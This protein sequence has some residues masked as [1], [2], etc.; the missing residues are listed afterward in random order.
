MRFFQQSQCFFL[1]TYLDYSFPIFDWLCLNTTN[2]PKKLFV[3]NDIT[4]IKTRVQKFSQ[5]VL[6]FFEIYTF[7]FQFGLVFFQFTTCKVGV[8]AFSLL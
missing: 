4:I 3:S 6:Q 1:F 7:F 5:Y 2:E 8:V